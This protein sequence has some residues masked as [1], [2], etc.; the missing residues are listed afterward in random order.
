MKT[1]FLKAIFIGSLVLCQGAMVPTA[2]AQAG[3]GSPALPDAV[4]YPSREPGL[5]VLPGFQNPPAGYGEVAF[6]WWLGD[7]L[8]KERL[9]WQL[10]QLAGKGVMGL[11]VNYAHTDKGGRSYG[12][13]FP[14]EPALFSQNWWDLFG[15]FLGEART[16]GMAASL[17][18]YT[19]GAGQGWYFDEVLKEAPEL[20]GATLAFADKLVEGGAEINWDVPVNT[21]GASAV[22]MNGNTAVASSLVDLRSKLSGQQL[23]WTPPPGHW[24]LV[25]SYYKVNDWSIDPMNPRTGDKIIEKFFQRFEDR[26]PGQ[27]GKGLN[28]F[29]S[30]E[31]SFGVSGNLWNNLIAAEFQKRKGYDLVAELPALFMDIGPRT[32]KVRL[33]Y[34]DVMV[35]M[36]EEGFF[37]PVYEWH[38]KRGMI[39]GCDH[40]GRGRNVVEFG[41]YFRT[42]RWNQGPGCD[43]PRLSRDITKNKV[44]SSIAHLY[45]RPRT[46]LE[47][48]Y[49]SGWGTSSEQLSDATF[50]NFAMGQNLLTLHGLYYS[51]HGGW[52]EWAPPCNHFRQPYWQH[53]GYF[54][55]CVERLSYVLSQGHHRCDVAIIYPVAAMEA[56]MDGKDAVSTAFTLGNKLYAGGVDFDFMD[57]ESLARAQMV[58]GEL[59]VSGESYKTLVLPAMKA[60]RH[61]T[62]E[63][64]AEFYRQGGKVVAIGS[65][66]TASDRSGRDDAE[67]AKLVKEMFGVDA[68]MAS[69]QT[70]QKTQRNSKGGQAI[71]IPQAEPAF[72]I[73]TSLVP[74]DFQVLAGTN[75]PLIMHRQIGSRDVYFVYGGAKDAECQF[76]SRGHVQ[77]WEPWTGSTRNLPV[78]SQ[79]ATSTRL[80]LPLGER[81][82][83]LIV[84]SPGTATIEKESNQPPALTTLP[85]EGN[86]EFE[87]KPTR[88]NRFGDYQW[89]PTPTFIAA[90]SRQVRYSD[91]SALNP[92]W[93]NP[94]LDD[95]Q[96]TKSTVSFG[97]KFWKLGPLPEKA[98][99]SA[100]ET[101]L[102]SLKQIT[103]ETPVEVGGKK[104]YWKPYEFSWRWGIENDPGHQGYHG[105]K[106]EVHNEFIGL[107]KMK[108]S[109]TST[110]YDPE[111]G[112]T[113]YYLWSSVRSAQDTSVYPLIGGMVP[114]ALWINKTRYQQVPEQVTLSSG[115]NPLLLRY[116]T[117]GRG[118]LVFSTV[119][120]A[121]SASSPPTS[122]FS[123]SA[124]YIWYPQDT[125]KV[126]DRYFRKSFQLDAKLLTAQLH[127]TC[128]N[129]YTVWVNGQEVGRGK[130]WE[131]VDAYNVLKH[132]KTGNNVIAVAAHND[133]AD[134][135]LIAELVM[136]AGKDSTPPVATDASWRCAKQSG[137]N[138]QQIAFDDSQW[139]KSQVIAGFRES[140]WFKHK[141][142]PPKL[143]AT[144]DTTLDTPARVSNPN[145]N[146]TWYLA[147]DILDFDY[148]P[149]VSTPAGWYRFTAPPGL[150]SFKVVTGQGLKLQAWCD[151]KAL[152]AIAQTV[153]NTDQ[154]VEHHIQLPQPVLTTSK[155][156]LRIEQRQ[157]EYGGS[158][159]REAITLDCVPGQIALGD[160]SQI[161][162]LSSYS[163]GAWYRRNF[164]LT[165]EQAKGQVQLD[166]G[167][168]VSSAEVRVNGQTAGVRLAPP[169]Q[170][171]L[172]RLV[173]AGDNRLE[174]LVYNTL[175]NHYVTIPTRYRGMITSGLM[176]PVKLEIPKP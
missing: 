113:R 116:D 167:D 165:A 2:C 4:G 40:G 138:W 94:A 169:W 176:G 96:W 132:L 74:R 154:S 121:S 143:N 28:F 64:A 73:I 107:G 49:S 157:G 11:Q 136:N 17:S 159:L 110:S 26:N 46:W 88:D 87:L 27:S 135:G 5:D 166:L 91:E 15:W 89:P 61:S 168:L 170:F 140:L 22:Q 162:G 50:A 43:Q 93:E 101:T 71:F 78:L 125:T 156:A 175:G 139:Q 12:L 102:S 127:I 98:D 83:Q 115:P 36:Q 141:N 33:D 112:G 123:A 56:G 21:I 9:Q 51:T 152:S 52:W 173:K 108:T 54:L 70:G 66:P 16:R 20:R 10:D 67:V 80:R 29:F 103:P 120:K 34:T 151:G 164:T 37:K 145:M 32:P 55:K 148:R 23:R 149:Q 118:S 77:L 82:P 68:R 59:Q 144:V 163:G 42:Q 25:A 126:S 41:D 1:V 134:A 153:R 84:F 161:D 63:K 90:E 85:L 147:P 97:P 47:G 137:I 174:I 155:I 8:T 122:A 124:L 57:F 69:A 105:L 44:A 76:R 39:Y 95:A 7:P 30:D 19:L 131:K 104:Y 172:T 117:P 6:Y 150:R 171:N 86:W 142:G 130:S 100:L 18:D 114:A 13:T 65:L 158:A 106:E 38:Q 48:Y 45:L 81:E 111:P 146:M 14:S 24:R 129:A 3:F 99:T 109:G 31:L 133:G 35:A 62:L 79:D 60:L 128:D 58:G 75:T 92:G 160:W 72:E 53:M 119:K